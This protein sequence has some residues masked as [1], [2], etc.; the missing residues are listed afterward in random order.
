[1]Y[2]VLF[3]IARPVL[4]V[5]GLLDIHVLLTCLLFFTLLTDVDIDA[6]VC[7]SNDVCRR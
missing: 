1:M 5:A 4:V 2:L 6:A 3:V 7:Y